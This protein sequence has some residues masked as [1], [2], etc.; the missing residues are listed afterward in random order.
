MNISSI[1]PRVMPAPQPVQTSPVN[2]NTGTMVIDGTPL[3]GSGTPA[4]STIAAGSATSV[5]TFA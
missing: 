2:L 3:S 1:A 4:G 5:N